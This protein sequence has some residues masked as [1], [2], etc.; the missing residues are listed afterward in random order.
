MRGG[1]SGELRGGGGGGVR[2]GGGGFRGSGGG[3]R[4]GG[5]GFAGGGRGGRSRDGA[6]AA[7]ESAAQS[8]GTID[9][10]FAPLPPVESRG[11]VWTFVDKQLKPVDVRV[12]ITDGTFTELLD[13]GE[14]L[15]ADTQV[16]TGMTGLETRTATPAG[17]GNPFQQGGRGRGGRGGPGGFGPPF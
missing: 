2:A 13:G 15:S 7:P 9:A 12:G 14:S 11:R 4:G 8:A 17:A 16:V 10:L 6:P 3:F 1:G 5:G